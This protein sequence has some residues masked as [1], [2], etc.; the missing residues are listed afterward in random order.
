MKIIIVIFIL[1]SWTGFHPVE[2]QSSSVTNTPTVTQNLTDI[3]TIATKYG[4]KNIESINSFENDS[5]APPYL[6]PVASYSS[7]GDDIYKFLKGKYKLI[8]SNNRDNSEGRLESSKAVFFR[9]SKKL[10]S[11]SSDSVVLDDKPPIYFEDS[12][13]L[14]MFTYK[15]VGMYGKE[16]VSLDGEIIFNS[17]SNV[18]FSK[19]LPLVS[20]DSGEM[21]SIL[22]LTSK[23]RKNIRCNV[24]TK[25]IAMDEGGKFVIAYDFKQK[26]FERFDAN[27][28]LIWKR[29]LGSVDNLRF[30]SFSSNQK[31]IVFNDVKEKQTLYFDSI[32]GL[33]V[34]K[35]PNV[36][37]KN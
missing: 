6:I 19:K 7:A 20:F 35:I 18:F 15:N 10:W 5:P 37:S 25:L 31:L 21:I 24:D 23:L 13:Y 27:G 2:A 11:V 16:L 22:N 1:L 32:S 30:V 29:T 17:I 28:I 36:V 12:G 34:L 9:K 3:Q 8:V 33:C 14:L 4:L 26:M